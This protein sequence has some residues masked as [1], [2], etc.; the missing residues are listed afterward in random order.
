[1]IDIL[2]RKEIE[3]K[4]KTDSSMLGDYTMDIQD[5]GLSV[6]HNGKM[7]WPWESIQ[8][9]L[10]NGDCCHIRTLDGKEVVIVA[11][12]I[13]GD[14][15]FQVFVRLCVTLHY[16]QPRLD[17]SQPKKKVKLDASPTRGGPSPVGPNHPH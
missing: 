12:K 3:D 11:D 16:F 8:S 14:T 5:P 6:A 13:G 9:I 15:A 4:L 2:A 17:K 10:A 7:F 1:M